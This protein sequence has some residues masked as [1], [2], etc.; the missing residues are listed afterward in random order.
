[1]A[2]SSSEALADVS[3]ASLANQGPIPRPGHLIGT[4]VL[5]SVC[6]SLGPSRSS[7]SYFDT[8]SRAYSAWNWM[9][10]FRWPP[11]SAVDV[12]YRGTNSQPTAFTA[13]PGVEPGQASCTSGTPSPSLSTK[14]R[15]CE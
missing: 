15:S 6:A 11:S 1:M 5:V 10:A 2:V 9:T 13:A 14:L 7:N 8:M 3:C 12:V 4:Q